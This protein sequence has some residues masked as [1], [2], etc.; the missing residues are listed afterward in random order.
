MDSPF[1]YDRYVTGKNFIGRKADC[2]IL[3]NLLNANENVVMYEPPKTGKM[4]VVQQTLFNMRISGK[5]FSVASMD[6][7]NKRTM[8]QFLTCFGTSVIRSVAS[9]PEEYANAVAKCLPDTHFR[10]DR[11]QFSIT[12]Q[13]VS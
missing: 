13:V 10:F 11:Q 4:S 9:T 1:I 2:Q 6:F 3:S 8:E 5:S 7:F 12:D